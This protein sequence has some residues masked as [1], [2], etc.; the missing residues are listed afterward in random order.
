MAIQSAHIQR[1]P[2]DATSGVLMSR[3]CGNR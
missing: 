1:V 2:N 3:V